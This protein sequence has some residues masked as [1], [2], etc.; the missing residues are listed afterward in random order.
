MQVSKAIAE[1]LFV[2]SPVNLDTEARTTIAFRRILGRTPAES[3]LVLIK[4]SAE[5]IETQL[6]MDGMPQAERALSL[7]TVL[8]QTLVT[9]YEFLFIR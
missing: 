1:S 3:E 9:G 4:K 7:W 6:Q 2:D 8:S 5:K